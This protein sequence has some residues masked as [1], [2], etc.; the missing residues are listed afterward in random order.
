MEPDFSHI[1]L[2]LD[3]PFTLEDLKNARRELLAVYHPDKTVDEDLKGHYT[4]VTQRINAECNSLLP[5]CVSAE[6]KAIILNARNAQHQRKYGA[7][8][9]TLHHVRLLSAGYWLVLFLS[10]VGYTVF[11]LFSD[12]WMNSV[13]CAVLLCL[14]LI[15]VDTR[16]VI[17]K[18]HTIIIIGL[19]AIT[20]NVYPLIVAG[21]TALIIFSL[22]PKT[23]A[24]KSSYRRYWAMVEAL[25]KHNS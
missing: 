5:M 4:K 19:L 16:D 17:P 8:V 2:K 12:H 21:L 6:A 15:S 25:H 10:F 13:Y 1:S 20:F 14:T 3:Q 24:R 22:Y 23:F 11:S 18:R 7:D 9:N